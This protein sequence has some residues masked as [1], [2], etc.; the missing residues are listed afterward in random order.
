[1]QTTQIPVSI[2]SKLNDR[3][4]SFWWGSPSN[5]RKTLCLK[6]WDALCKP[7]SC[8]G[9]GLRKMPDFNMALLVKWGWNLLTCSNSLCLAILR[10]RYLPNDRFFDASPKPGDSR[11]WKSIISL[12]E[13]FREEACYVVGN[14]FIE[15]IDLPK[16]VCPKSWGQKLLLPRHKLNWWQFIANT[17]PT[18]EKINTLFHTE[19]FS[20]NSS[21]EGL[22]FLWSLK[23]RDNSPVCLEVGGRNILLFASVLFDLLWKYQNSITHGGQVLDPTPICES[24]I[25]AYS[26]L[27]DVLPKDTIWSSSSWTPPPPG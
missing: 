6:A 4:R 1:M 20:C 27:V 24:I 9:L 21:L 2:C 13:L 3:I 12:K 17:F 25:R 14:G 5:G 11:F 23:A 16:E 15:N 26:D 22:R 18:R 10:A 19:M 7:K 8:G